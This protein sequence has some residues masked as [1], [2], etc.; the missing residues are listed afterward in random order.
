MST[1][2]V[3]PEAVEAQ[4]KRVIDSQTFRGAER[5]RTLLRFV[6]EETLHGR[7]GHLKEYTLG[8]QALGRGEGFDS[9]IDPIARVEASRL[10]SRL[11]V[12][13]ATEGASDPVRISLPKG[14]YAP[15]FEWRPITSTPPVVQASEGVKARAVPSAGLSAGRIGRALLEAAVGLA[16][17]AGVWSIRRPSDEPPPSEVRLE[18][19][20]P[21]TTDPVSL[22]VSPDGRSVVF[23]ASTEGRSR[24]WIRG[25]DSTTPRELAGTEYASLPFWAP[26]GRSIGFF[27]DGRI[28][29]IELETGLVRVISTAL[30][31]AGAAWNSDGVILHAVV[32]D[33]PL[34]R[35]SAAGLPPTPI[36]QLTAGQTGHRGPA[37]LPDGRHFLFYA[38]GSPDVRGIYVGELGTGVVRRLME[39][40]TPAVFVAPNHLLYVQHSTLFARDIDP[41]T[42]TLRG[43]PM[44]L[45]DGISADVMGGVAAFS[46][47][48]GTIIYRTGR[49]AGKRQFRWLDRAG[50][51]LSRVGSP[52]VFGPS[53]ASMS[54]DGRLLAVQR[55]L[56][57]NTDIW[58]V[59][60]ERGT[61]VRFT[62]EPQADIAPVWSPQGDRIIYASQKDG[63]FQLFEKRLDGT[64]ARMLLNTPESKQVTDWS[65]D[66]RYLLFRTIMLAPNSDIDI[67]ALPLDGD[68]R[69]FAVV[70]TPL[71][72]RDAQFSPDGNWIAYHS[73]ESGQH[74]VYV[75]PFQGAGDRM[76][77][78]KDGGVQARWRSDGR[79]L[80]YLTL[81]GELVAVPIALRP[82][83]RSL[84]PGPAV[85]LFQARVGPVQGVALHSYIVA[86]DGQLFLVETAI[87]ETPPPI[88]LILNWKPPAE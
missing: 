68:H 20:T 40:D 21:P 61:P 36:T 19:V 24:L 88:S 86:P 59:D 11:D 34:F 84:Q 70:R 30:V 55:S 37:F 17:I 45:A 27:A 39:T 77:I 69:P 67:W 87:E 28:K 7:A 58:L 12:Y 71:E 66:G 60:V 9:R 83:S 29:Q 51:E 57:G 32:P 38:M 80:F 82:G 18:M 47:S 75:Q 78:S 26:D 85:P 73:N 5:S 25:L 76:R 14:A 53:Y 6:V 44:S 54:P 63:A 46:A 42:V 79:E 16:L 33:G 50:K 3:S 23:V 1:G 48:T 4:L 13:Y 15:V 65:R 56:D 49:S 43:R 31:P 81:K 74:E 2:Q 35:T 8:S 72:E 64:P 22:A 10:R 41:R 62:T 52:E